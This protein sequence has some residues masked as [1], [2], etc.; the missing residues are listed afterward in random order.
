MSELNTKVMD[1][2]KGPPTLP[3][4]G[5]AVGSAKAL[6]VKVWEK[7]LKE[8][9]GLAA[10][11]LFGSGGPRASKTAPGARSRVSSENL[12]PRRRRFSSE[13]QRGRT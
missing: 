5:I 13:G 4:Q 2:P 12:R 3:A 8:T 6:T 1:R 7:K 9:K 11:R 10:F